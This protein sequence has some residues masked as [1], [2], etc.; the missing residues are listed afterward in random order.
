MAN[1][2]LPAIWKRSIILPV[3]KPGIPAYRPI[4]L[5][6]PASKLLERLILPSLQS[7]FQLNENQ[8]GFRSLHST[9]TALLPLVTEVAAGFHE[10]NPP[11]RTIAAAI[12]LFKAFD[13]VNHDILITKIMDSGLDAHVVRWLSTF[14]KGREQAVT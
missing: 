13:V 2:D 1:A 8:H 6:C 4:S 3:L 7:T 5:L 11:K 10:R 9:S 12:D 14:L